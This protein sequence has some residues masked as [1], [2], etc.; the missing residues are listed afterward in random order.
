[1]TSVLALSL[2][3]ML[4][5]SSALMGLAAWCVYL[6]AVRTGQF[7]NVEEAAEAVVGQDDRD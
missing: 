1:M 5:A 3:A 7:R 4:F 6:W 2:H